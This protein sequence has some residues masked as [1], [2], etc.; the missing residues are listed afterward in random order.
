MIEKMLNKMSR[1]ESGR[2]GAIALNSDPRKK[3]KASLKAAQTRLA[4]DPN[5]FRRM[6]HL[7]GISKKS[8]K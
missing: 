4:E 8:K 5:T 1:S 3:S 7:A 2:L 6:G